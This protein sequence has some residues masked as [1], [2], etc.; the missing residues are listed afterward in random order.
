MVYDA[1]INSTLTVNCFFLEPDSVKLTADGDLTYFY[2]QEEVN[3]QFCLFL[4]FV[5]FV[6]MIPL[7]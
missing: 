5:V 1:I 2:K 6:S 7:C 3:D 4:G